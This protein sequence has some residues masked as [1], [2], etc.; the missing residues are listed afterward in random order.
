[1]PLTVT[2]VVFVLDTV[3]FDD[4][5]VDDGSKDGTAVQDGARRVRTGDGA[6][7]SIGG[8]GGRNLPSQT[9][10]GVGPPRKRD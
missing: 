6:F 2:V 10:P 9:G 1:M 7:N 3:P 8:V 4:D 5:D